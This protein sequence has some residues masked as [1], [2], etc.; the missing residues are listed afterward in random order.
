MISLFIIR[1][2]EI[3]QDR[4]GRLWKINSSGVVVFYGNRHRGAL[5][6]LAKYL[7]QPLHQILGAQVCITL[8]HLH[9]FVARDGGD[10]LVAQATLD[11]AGDRFMAQIMETQ[12]PMPTS[13]KVRCQAGRNS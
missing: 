11:Q 5:A 7:I 10:F 4:L 13:F 8:Q 12:A 1:R 6:L 2:H 3:A 9:G